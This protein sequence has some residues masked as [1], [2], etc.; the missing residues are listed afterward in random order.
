MIF[1]SVDLPAPFS[2]STA[3]ISPGRTVRSMPSLATT[4]GYTLRM[5]R[6]S[7]RGRFPSVP[8]A[9]AG[10]LTDSPTAIVSRCSY[11]TGARSRAA[12]RSCV[13]GCS[14]VADCR[15]TKR[16]AADAQH[17]GGDRDGDHL[18][19]LARDPF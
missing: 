4:D 6:S 11:P 7:S 15:L 5:P 8:A 13:V 17:L 9:A 16:L 14:R 19:L 18:G 3:W 10:V 12:P 2:P 1:I